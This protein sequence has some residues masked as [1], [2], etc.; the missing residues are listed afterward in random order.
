M[1]E[2]CRGNLLEAPAEAL[3]N[4]VN[5]V[6]VMGKGIALQFRQA[7]PEMFRVY[8]KACK[9]GDVRL[10]KIHVFDRGG[11]TGGPRWIINFP[12]KKHWRAASHLGDVESGLVDLVVTIRRLG[13]RSIAI[14][15]LG[16]GHGG[17]DWNDVRPRIESALAEL[18][19]VRV[20]LYAPTGAPASVEMPNRTQRPAMTLGQAALVSLM[21]RY[22]K[23]L[24]DP[25]VSLLEVH[26]LM[27][28]L[29]SAGEPLRHLNFTARAYG[30]YSADLRHGLIRMENHLTRGYGSGEDDPST[31]I[32]L[33]PGAVEAADAYL[34]D[35]S[36][37][38]LRIERVATLI[39]GFEDTYGMELLSSVHW[40]MHHE[41]AGSDDP[42]GA[43]EAVHRWNDRKRRA[44]K[45]EHLRMAWDRLKEQRWDELAIRD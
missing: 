24:L 23:G 27:Y 43:I 28:F 36:D 41:A 3:V 10:G 37:T 38:Q 17:L 5:T 22:L 29:K 33:V 14:P 2:L 35:H 9:A 15:P 39:R 30:P 40:V 1:I 11:M 13:L 26:K 42:E 32:E 31:P 16:C 19:D 8:A 6:G 7:Y 12:T 21:D 20:M 18:S 45:A 25:F 44:L 34:A 4:T